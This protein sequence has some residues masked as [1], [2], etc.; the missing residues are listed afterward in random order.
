METE[1]CATRGTVW[2]EV[3]WV[4]LGEAWAEVSCEV[5]ETSVLEG[6]VRSHHRTRNGRSHDTVIGI[7]EK[8]RTR[9]SRIGNSISV[10]GVDS[11]H[12]S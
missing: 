3:W 8:V 1:A 12:R 7:K 10:E 2:T 6:V 11:E 9:R 4:V 5:C